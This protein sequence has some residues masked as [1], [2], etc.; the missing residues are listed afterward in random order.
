M[1]LVYYLV[2]L[3]EEW[4]IY[5]IYNKY[6]NVM[7]DGT[8]KSFFIS[9]QDENHSNGKNLSIWNEEMSDVMKVC[10]ESFPTPLGKF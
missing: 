6:F 5:L 8:F 9:Q 10:N 7:T 4:E 1:L 3:C 2:T